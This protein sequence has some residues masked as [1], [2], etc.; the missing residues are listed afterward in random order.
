M[1]RAA[2]GDDAVAQLRRNLAEQRSHPA[3]ERFERVFGVGHVFIVP[4]GREQAAVGNRLPPVHNQV[5]DQRQPF[6]GFV[7][8]VIGLPLV[9]VDDKF[10]H[11][12]NPDGFAHG[13]PPSASEPLSQHIRIDGV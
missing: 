4:E 1:I 3:D 10:I 11:H 8:H 7:D 6:F 9:E 12:L 2:V 5:F 13:N